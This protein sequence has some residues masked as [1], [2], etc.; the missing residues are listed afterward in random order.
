MIISMY[1]LVHIIIHVRIRFGRGFGGEDLGPFSGPFKVD[2]PVI[3][4]A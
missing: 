3:V 2:R 1:R 4:G